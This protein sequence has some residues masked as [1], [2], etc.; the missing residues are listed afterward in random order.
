MYCIQIYSTK[1]VQN[2]KKK[3]KNLAVS[4]T[5]TIMLTSYGSKFVSHKIVSIILYIDSY[6]LDM[7]T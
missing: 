5:R 1:K 6:L 3:F 2:G 7:V 4:N